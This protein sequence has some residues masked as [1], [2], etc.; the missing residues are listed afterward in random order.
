MELKQQK[1]CHIVGKDRKKVKG[2]GKHKAV[3]GTNPVKQKK[4]VFAFINNKLKG[5][6]GEVCW[7][8]VNYIYFI[9]W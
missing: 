1:K 6:K 3:T 8:N 5:R 2:K 9:E 4:D 7:K